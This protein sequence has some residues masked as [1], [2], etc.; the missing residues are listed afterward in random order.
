MIERS[1]FDSPSPKG[2]KH[3]SGQA[4]L[5]RE[6]LRLRGCHCCQHLQHSVFPAN[7]GPRLCTQHA[8]QRGPGPVGLCMPSGPR[9]PVQAG[10]LF[11]PFQRG[12]VHKGCSIALVSCRAVK[13]FLGYTAPAPCSLPSSTYPRSERRLTGRAALLDCR[14]LQRQDC[15]IQC[16]KLCLTSVCPA[17]SRTHTH[18][19]GNE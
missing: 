4:W 13:Y 12:R 18:H 14:L 15:P 9:A 8:H 17:H 3:D 2:S 6:P 1:S 5:L 7:R 11:L 16:P 19:L 10:T